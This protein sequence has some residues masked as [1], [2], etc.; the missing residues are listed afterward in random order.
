M[1]QESETRRATKKVAPEASTTGRFQAVRAITHQP[2]NY[3]F[4]SAYLVRERSI[5]SSHASPASQ[6]AWQAKAS[7]CPGGCIPGVSRA[8]L[9][10]PRISTLSLRSYF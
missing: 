4:E 9:V 10:S 5:L 6:Y 8:F 1:S 2:A 3:A 7:L